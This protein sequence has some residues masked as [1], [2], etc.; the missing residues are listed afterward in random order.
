M[1][2]TGRTNLNSVIINERFDRIETKIDKLSEAMVS[3]ARTEEKL[4]ALDTDK[5]NLYDRV[6][7][8]SEKLDELAITVTTNSRTVTTINKLMWILIATAIAT[9]FKVFLI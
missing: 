9:G 7:K 1:A 6:N 8:H 2:T 5:Q 4:V 3:I